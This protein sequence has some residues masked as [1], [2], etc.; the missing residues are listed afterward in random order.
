MSIKAIGQRPDALRDKSVNVVPP[1]EDI[2]LAVGVTIPSPFIPCLSSLMRSFRLMHNDDTTLT[3][4][5]WP[6]TA[7]QAQCQTP[8]AGHIRNY[9][10][11]RL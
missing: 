3:A 7:Q 6:V 1:V 5:R 2:E 11:P 10:Y 9:T 8:G 4:R